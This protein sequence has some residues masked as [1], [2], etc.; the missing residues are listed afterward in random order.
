LLP[1]PLHSL[2]AVGADT[3]AVVDMV[4]VAVSTEGAEAF[5]V[6]WAEVDFVPADFAE[7]GLT[8]RAEALGAAASAEAMVAATAT[9]AMVVDTADTVTTITDQVL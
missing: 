7:A 4:E 5:M 9:V 3:A 2:V 6:A 8:L 1:R